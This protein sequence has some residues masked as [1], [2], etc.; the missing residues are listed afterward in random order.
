M[1]KTLLLIA[2]LALPLTA[3]ESPTSDGPVSLLDEPIFRI[4]VLK[5]LP[6]LDGR[7]SP[8]EWEDASA[9]SAF[10]SSNVRQV[11]YPAYQH[12]APHQ[13]QSRVFAGYDKEHL[14][15]AYVI[16]TYPEDSWLK[17]R[18]RFPDVYSHPLYGLKQDDHMEFELRPF[19]ELRQGYRWGMFKWFVNPIGVI[20]DQHWSL[21]TGQGKRWQ[22]KA[23]VRSGVEKTFWVTEMKIPLKEMR[24]EGYAGKL[25]NGRDVIKL[26]PPDG[27][28]YRLWFKN[29]IGGAGM[30]VV[31][32]DQHIWNTTKTRL[33]FDSKAVGFQVQQMGP[34][35]EDILDVKVA[36]KNHNT[37]SETVRLGFFVESAE[38]LIYSTYTDDQTKDGLIEL[39]PG[40]SLK[41]RFKRKFPGIS[42][43]EN[44]LW[45]DVRTAGRPGKVLFQNRLAKFHSVDPG[46]PYHEWR[47]Q[48]LD[49]L[50]K[51]RPPKKD[52]DFKYQYSPY[53]NRLSA[54][55][56][57]GIHG[58]SE[59]A[60]RAAEAKLIVM[61][62]NEDEDELVT[63]IARFN[64]EFA[65]F[66]LNDLPALK[67]GYYKVSLLLF[68]KN[69]RIV[70]ERN[71]EPF[72]KGEFVW[73]KNKLGMEDIVWAPF[74]P[75]KVE[76][77]SL[78]M[79]KHRIAVADTG[80]PAQIEIFPDVRELPLETR[81]KTDTRKADLSSFVP[82]GR[83]PQ[84]RAPLRLEAIVKGQRI[85][86]VAVGAAKTTR[87]WQS[88]VVFTSKL[89]AGP[90]DIELN[91]QY[92]CDGSLLCRMTYG[93]EQ[94]EEVDLLELVMDVDGP[95]D[96]RTGGMYHMIPASGLEMTLPMEDG[97]LWDSANPDHL[98][99]LELYYSKFVPFFTFGSGDRGWS[100][101]CDSDQ[102][103]AIDSE[104]STMTLER[105]KDMQATLRVK[106][107]N[108]TTTIQGRR[109]IEFYLITHPTKSKEEGYR[110]IQWLDWRP[111]K[112]AGIGLKCLPNDGPWGI[113]GSDETFEYFLKRYPHGSPRLYINRN[114]VNS[115]IPAL[116]KGAY[117]GE[118]L[119]HSSAKVNSSP[120]DKRGG[121]NQPWIRPGK[122]L[123]L[124]GYGQSWEDYFVYWL[125]R[126]IR[127]GK[128]PGWWWDELFVPLR[129]EC[130]A[131][132]QAYFRDP[133]DVKQ[134]EL[135]Y[136]ANFATLHAK[137][138]LKRLAKL[139]KKNG[140][141]NVT[142]LW[143]TSCTTFESY[144]QDSELVESASAYS[145]SYDI[146]NVT[147]FP[148]SMFRYASNTNKSLTT[149]I[150]PGLVGL[151]ASVVMPGDNPSLDRGVIGRALL[152]DIG[153]N[154]EIANVEQLVKAINI[155]SDFGYF[156]EA[157]T[158]TIPYW[159]SR[160]FCR[161]G[162]EFSGDAFETTEEDPFAN[163]YVTIYRRPYGQ[164]G[165]RR[166]YKALF[167]IQ[168]ESDD[169]I[170]GRLH[171]L[172]SK[173]L[174][175]GNNN[176]AVRNIR[177]RYP[178]PENLSL[179][180]RASKGFSYQ[181]V[182]ALED[183]ESMGAITKATKAQRQHFVKTEI[184]GPIYIPAHDYRILYAHYDP[185][186]Q[187]ATHV[188]VERKSRQ[189]EILRSK[190]WWEE[191]KERKE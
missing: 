148:I 177:T 15:L 173:G 17:A 174:L 149:R 107:V 64:G 18:G 77:S 140:I 84:L 39:V 112:Y 137:D 183:M 118:W 44:Y 82:N 88:E 150:K 116:Q 66:F 132:G 138:M 83:G 163:T 133:K 50:I 180:G 153:V 135:P 134:N 181:G 131:N 78:E 41:L 23:L 60:R 99:P 45:F 31:L 19:S 139:Q 115:G 89:K 87:T 186:G 59:D 37:R 49:T 63:E 106:F 151:K 65:T 142:S 58:A 76:G 114:W 30:Y 91:T 179:D 69:K 128:V 178:L 159:R 14:F 35:M 22:A 95:V 146:D 5:K 93:T 170:R 79:L 34:L 54:V 33:V 2:L 26:P 121:Y 56:D 25:E 16:S 189:W 171:M 36:L 166:G 67:K 169:P 105:D 172:D 47:E 71:P 103:W 123:V 92:E 20:S 109:S 176:L 111:E 61:R 187:H 40:Q 125:E 96:Y 130:V 152:H 29:G 74:T 144:A 147:R 119:L 160:K 97:V 167:I 86:A 124:I 117:N 168:N 155:L 53:T 46:P 136:Q 38:G 7:F 154:T 158:E 165:N 143:A 104:G 129:S 32:F 110:R 184:F 9:L 100:W 62:S 127:I 85:P 164:A 94:A 24:S 75:I 21:N 141:P 101:I 145:L 175:G 52:F 90:I 122:G 72:Y 156:D 182:T 185:T 43:Q 102:G 57:K 28:T 157:S 191:W 113:D 98:E 6:E 48:K 42:K 10:W 11:R 162:E 51:M 12:Q 8:E 13:I 1:Q 120:L 126:Q 188:P 73:E 161:F 108:H 3:E 70:G 81:A 27:T 4:P 68:D 190:T 80:L 55:V